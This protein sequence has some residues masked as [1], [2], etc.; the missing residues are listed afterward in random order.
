[1]STKCLIF[2]D[3]SIHCFTDENKQEIQSLMVKLTL[4]MWLR[5]CL[6]ARM[7]VISNKK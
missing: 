2:I 3:F 1:M 4:F 6:L 5:F 7:R